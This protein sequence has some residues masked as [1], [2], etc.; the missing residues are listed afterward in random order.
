MQTALKQTVQTGC[1]VEP[2]TSI[3]PVLA[4]LSPQHRASVLIFGGSSFEVYG[5][6][7]DSLIAVTRAMLSSARFSRPFPLSQT[8]S[9]KI[10]YFLYTLET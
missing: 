10:S 9:K 6:E 1:A 7:V 2:T 8:Q 3:H 4:Y 5:T